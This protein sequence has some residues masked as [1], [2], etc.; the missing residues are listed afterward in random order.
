MEEPEDSS[1]VKSSD[2]PAQGD[3]ENGC[4]MEAYDEAGLSVISTSSAP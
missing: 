4:S 2:S 3:V 1:E